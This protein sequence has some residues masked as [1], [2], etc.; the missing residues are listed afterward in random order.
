MYQV[1]QQGLG[2]RG[3]VYLQQQRRLHV[4]IIG[5]LPVNLATSQ[6][7]VRFKQ[8]N[9]GHVRSTN[10]YP[11]SH[12][13]SDRNRAKPMVMARYSLV[14]AESDK[15][16]WPEDREGSQLAGTTLARILR[17]INDEYTESRREGI[18]AKLC[19]EDPT[20]QVFY[21]AGDRNG[22]I[23]RVLQELARR[24]RNNGRFVSQ[25]ARGM[26]QAQRDAMAA[27]GFANPNAAQIAGMA[28]GGGS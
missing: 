5:P 14:E 24:I 6:A 17:G 1:S 8:Q 12:H 18:I 21:D 11:P 19:W 3:G 22:A 10:L 7:Q 15:L 28:A 26:G 27:G 16:E 13:C 25:E 2:L 9:P 4:Q 23:F 20:L